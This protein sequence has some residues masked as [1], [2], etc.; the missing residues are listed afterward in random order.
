MKDL[1]TNG[2]KAGEITSWAIMFVGIALFLWAFYG[3][4][5]PDWTYF[6]NKLHN[7]F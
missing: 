2:N 3:W 4:L 6:L 1:N 7:I 5:N